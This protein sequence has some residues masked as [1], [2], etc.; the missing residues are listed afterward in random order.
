MHKVKICLIDVDSRHKAALKS[1]FLD[2]C[3]AVI[4][5]VCTR[6]YCLYYKTHKSQAGTE[7]TPL[8]SDPVKSF[9]PES[10]QMLRVF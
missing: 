7:I 5:L 3:V 9:P 10:R 6:G 2:A 1:S 4:N 8:K